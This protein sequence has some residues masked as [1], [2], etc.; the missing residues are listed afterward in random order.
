MSHYIKLKTNDN[1]TFQAYL[2]QP[3][4]KI[5]GGI[6]IIQEIFGVNKHIREICNLYSKNGYLAIAPCLF[7]REKE[8]IELSYDMTG[9]TEGR[10][11]KDLL[12]EKSLNEIESSINYVCAAGN[13]GIIGYCWGGSLSWRAACTYHS[14]SCSVVYYG[15]EVPKLKHL[16]PK[17]PVMCHFGE[18]DK[19]IPINDVDEFMK[20][21][22][23]VDV[24]KYPADHGF[25]C[26]HRSQYNQK[27]S[28]IAFNRTIKFIEKN[29]S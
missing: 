10:R 25:N 6:I 17:C 12:N 1:H 11:L 23:K 8:M 27:C 15:G 2:S 13:V 26:N 14:L 29:V 9:V 18:F 4:H 22:E 3:K 28:E 21:N 7:D 16:E 20:I 19:S 5:K 24:F